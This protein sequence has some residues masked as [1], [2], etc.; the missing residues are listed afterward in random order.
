MNSVLAIVV[1]VRA[2][3]KRRKRKKRI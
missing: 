3:K 1:F 2:E